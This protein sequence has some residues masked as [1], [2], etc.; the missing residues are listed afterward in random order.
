MEMA[1][2]S[3]ERGFESV[4]FGE[5]FERQRTH[6]TAGFTQARVPRERPPASLP[7]LHRVSVVWFPGFGFLMDVGPRYARF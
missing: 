7:S 3:S 2:E 4:L 1:G 5:P 6:P